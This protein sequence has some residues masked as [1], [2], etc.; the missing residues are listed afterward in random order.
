M[1]IAIDSHSVPAGARPAAA[2]RIPRSEHVGSL[3]RP[4]ALL[5][6]RAR[7]RQGLIDDAELTAAEDAAILAA[8]DL[9]REIGLDVLTDGEYRRGWFGENLYRAIDGLQT[10]PARSSGRQWVGAGNQVSASAEQVGKEI[11]GQGVG[12]TAVRKLG[13]SGRIARHEADF[14]REHAAG[15][16]F[17][18]TSM[19]PAAYAENWFVPGAAAEYP[20]GV[21]LLADIAR[22]LRDE[23]VALGR[24]GVP[25]LQ[26]DSL[27]YILRFGDEGETARLLALLGVSREAAIDAILAADNLILDA[28]RAGGGITSV[29]MCRGNSRSA[30]NAKAG[31]YEVALRAL[32]ELHVDRL[33]LEYDSERAGSFAP[34]RH[35]PKDVIVVLGL[36]TSKFGELERRDDLLRRIDEA[37]AHHPLDRLALSPQCGFA[38]TAPGNLI[39]WDEQRRKLELVAAVAQEVWGGS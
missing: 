17:K 9:Q 36:V 11:V 6:A 28:V 27:S 33:L 30:W 16:L 1:S 3:L 2:R 26:L 21:D 7:H 5:E 15:E 14:L 34:L 25:Y 24:E 13:T 18:V 22:L 37:A 19:A 10:G 12:H 38:S 20:R 31:T 29:H 35:V 39:S 8:L 4:P 23:L 32:A